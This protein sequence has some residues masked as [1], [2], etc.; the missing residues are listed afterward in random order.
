MTTIT[1]YCRGGLARAKVEGPVTAGMVGIQVK[2]ECD[3]A[4]EG[5][6][7]TLKVRCAQE[8]RQVMLD[9]EN[10]A[11]LPFECLI[12]GQKLEC[13]LDGWDSGGKLRIP[14]SWAFCAMVKPSV[15]D[16]EGTEGAQPTPDIAQQLTR[17][18]EQVE[19]KLQSLKTDESAARFAEKVML[20]Y[21]YPNAI[22][23]SWDVNNSASIYKNY[24]VCI[25]GDGYCLPTHEAYAD[26]VKIFSIL[27]KTAPQT[28]LVGYVPIGVRNAGSGSNLPMET[29][30]ARVDAWVEMGADG[31]FLDEFGY[32]YGVTRA[33]QNEIVSYCHDLGLF[34]FANSWSTEYCFSDED[35]DFPEDFRPNP[36]KARAVLNE[37]D[38]YVYEHLFYNSYTD[39]GGTLR[40]EC[41]EPQRI[42]DILSYFT[43][44]KLD[45]KTYRE[46]FGTKVFSLDSIPT[47]ASIAQK[48]EMMSLS[49]IGAA[50]LNIDAIAFGDELWGAASDYHQWDFPRLDL[51]TDGRNS[52]SRATRPCTD[53]E[54][55]QSEFTWKWTASINGN[56]Y[57]IVFDVED[58]SDVTYAPEKRYAEC[59]GV[60]VENVW[61]TIYDFQRFLEE[62]NQK[63][64]ET[65]SLVSGIQKSVEGA[66]PTVLEAEKRVNAFMTET[67]GKVSEMEQNVERAIG[68]IQ[69]LT[70]GF[71]YLE[72]EW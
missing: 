34:V 58:P 70:A 56:L 25:F 63:L 18:L 3:K 59:N 7:K 16:M 54:G 44:E 14:T 45:G 68:D 31:I 12:A 55:N 37:N 11:I 22:N 1:L 28:R 42:D 27:K 38:Y 20:Y 61:L 62:T 23:N 60:K 6:T 41:A 9:G 64:E 17:R 29:L 51:K 2:V 10:Q 26:T 66:M 65:D 19:G 4:W 8:A 50:I 15:A 33:R 48:N 30:K 49:I 24:D 53:A 47:A 13:G 39:E 21:G 72:T 32:D 36:E 67:G 71:N 43:A 57:S 69:V 35:M 40:I 46:V 52:I 5:L